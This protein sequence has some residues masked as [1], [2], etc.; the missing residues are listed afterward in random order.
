MAVK[1]KG[2]P[3]AARSDTRHETSNTRVCARCIEV[4]E[5]HH[6]FKPAGRQATSRN[7]PAQGLPGHLRLRVMTAIQSM[8]IS[9]QLSSQN[10][11]LSLD[12]GFAGH[13][14]LR[15]S[16]QNKGQCAGRSCFFPPA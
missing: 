10:C 15:A 14:F 9:R 16:A 6:R 13:P 11:A 8:A 2:T 5:P 1:A 7:G 12:G 4:S 3:L